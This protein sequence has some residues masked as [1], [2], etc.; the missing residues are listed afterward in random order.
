MKNGIKRKTLYERF[1][2]RF[3]D[4]SLSLLALIFLAPLFIII[5]IISKISLGG[6]VIFCQYRPGKDGK[7]FK[8]YKFRSMTNK[9]DEKG[10]LLPDDKRITKFGR[11]LRKTSLDEL[12][13]II[14]ILKGDMSI[15]G[16]RPRLV[17]D[18]IFYSKEV[19]SAYSVKPGLTGPSQ[20]SGGRSESSWEM[21]F[22]EDLKYAQKITFRNDLKILFKT[23]GVLFKSDASCDGASTSKRDYYYCDYLL[24]NN[25]ITE[26][27]YALGL[28]MADRIITDNSKVEYQQNLHN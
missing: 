21:I 8:L 24:N 3:F 10:N 5:C 15:I 20:V 6:K 18:M 14:N 4:F 7:I 9:T 27:Q 12:P 28:A 25:K 19:L 26:K 11:F 1:F 17:K 16:P 22:E 13:Q 2:K 23:I